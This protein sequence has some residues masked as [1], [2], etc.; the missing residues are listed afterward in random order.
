MGRTE[1]LFLGKADMPYLNRTSRGRAAAMRGA[2]LAAIACSLALALVMGAPTIARA[3]T[4]PAIDASAALL[5]EP[6]SG[7]VLYE[8]NA[9]ETR[10]PASTTK[11]MC[12]LVVLEH[13]DL[14]DQV[15]VEE[16]DLDALTPDSSVAGFKPGEVLTV[17]QLL[18]GLLLPSGN[19]AAYILARAVGGSTEAFVQMMNDRAAEL[20]CTGTHFVNPCGLHDPDHYTTARDLIKMTEAAMENEE[21]AR[22]VAT[23]SFDLPATNV[24]PARTLYNTN[25]LINGNSSLYYEPAR[26]VKTGNTDEAGR[27]LVGAAEQD[28]VTLYSVALGCADGAVPAS[29]TETRRLFEWAYSEWAVRDV[30]SADSEVETVEVSD[31]HLDE[32][33]EIETA[34]GLSCLLPQDADLSAV[35]VTY[36]LPDTF[37]AP[38]ERGDVVGTATYELDGRTLGEVELVAANDVDLSALALMRNAAL[39]V[40]GSPVTW[41]ACGVIALAA[42]VSAVRAS[43][44]RRVRRDG[45]GR[46]GGSHFR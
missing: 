36:D 9:D 41:C 30:V 40:I 33:L 15:T 35:T 27:C 46:P 1:F 5:V 23:P 14:S 7:T 24:Q 39:A 34:D 16:G 3:L 10:Y 29:L 13:A 42:V 6:K 32:E 28:G 8:L 38:Y 45:S 17:E 22:I 31:A 4:D 18:Y 21:F 37:T 19:D 43:V 2:R 11:I 26:G 44:R 20:G 12:A 25:L